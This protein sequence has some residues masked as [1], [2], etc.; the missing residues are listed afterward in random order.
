MKEAVAEIKPSLLDRLEELLSFGLS[1]KLKFSIKA[2]LSMA[3]AYLIPLSQ[4]WNQAS[5]AGITVL[6]IAA[7][8]SVSESVLK[9]AMR[10]LGTIIG[11]IVGMTLIALFPQDRVFYL[12]ALSVTVSI[13]LYLV[14]A[15]K[16]DPSIFMLTAVTMMMVFKNGEI[17]DVFLYG[18]DRTYMTLFGIMVYTAVGVFLWPVYIEDTTT[19]NAHKLSKAQ[20]QL[21]ENRD[22]TKEER[23]KSLALLL[24]N[25]TQLEK[26]NMDTGSA[27]INMKQWHSMIYN[28][29][30]INEYLNLLSMHDKEAFMEHFDTYI[31]NYKLLESDI[32][33]LF[34]E[35]TNAWENQQEIAIPEAITLEYV[36]EKIK[37]LSHL[38]RASLITTIQ[39]MKNF[40]MS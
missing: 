19:Q 6:L 30:N 13:P 31:S 37:G 4:G 24:E 32:T 27:S 33:L 23:A 38:K 26:S 35:I 2:S 22:S 3:L 20:S 9:G 7:M 15:Y 21:F 28:Y 17:D 10:A 16:G 8:G 29:K 12:I 5:T 34:Q 18:V 1:D 11:G 25:E 36:T 39:D 40:I 14:R